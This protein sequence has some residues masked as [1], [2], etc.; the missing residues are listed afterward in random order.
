M[1]LPEKSVL[2][3]ASFADRADPL[4]HA[5]K[6]LQTNLE[7]YWRPHLQVV[8]LLKVGVDSSVVS[9][10]D[11][12]VDSEVDLRMDVATDWRL[13]AVRLSMGRLGSD[14]LTTLEVKMPGKLMVPVLLLA[15]KNRY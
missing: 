12:G 7:L 6:H 15:M 5:F 11:L 4:N 9:D 1:V 3:M 2:A 13:F 10:L 14:K 8:L